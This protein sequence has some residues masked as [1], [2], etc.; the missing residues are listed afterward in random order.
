MPAEQ[1]ILNEVQKIRPRRL[2]P[3]IMKEVK[4]ALRNLEGALEDCATSE[5][6]AVIM[7]GS[8]GVVQEKHL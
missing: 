8:K 5:D 6:M 2:D 4:R 3:K 1:I 7:A